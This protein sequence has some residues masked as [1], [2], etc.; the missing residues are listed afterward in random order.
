M[1]TSLLELGNGVRNL[2][3]DVVR[4]ARRTQPGPALLR[5][6]AGLAAMAAFA[7]VAPLPGQAFAFVP[8]GIAVALFPRTRIVTIAAAVAILLWLIDTIGVSSVPVGRLSVLAVS[9]YVMHSA[10]AIASVLPYD[11]AVAGAVLGRWARRVAVVTAVGVGVG[12]AGMAVIGQLPVQRSI[13]GPIVGAVV[14]AVLV[15]VLALQYRRP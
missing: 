3:V 12:L 2:V 6:V 1:R 9:L 4:R 7:V 5:S 14:A 8:V 15:A 11:A 10:A 13:I